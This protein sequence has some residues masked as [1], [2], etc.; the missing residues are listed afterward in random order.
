MQTTGSQGWHWAGAGTG[1]GLR[2]DAVCTLPSRY[3]H[4]VDEVKEELLGILLPVGGE[5]GVALANEGLE[6]PRGDAILH[7]L[8]G[9]G[10]DSA[11]AHQ[12]APGPF[13]PPIPG[14]GWGTGPQT[15]LLLWGLLPV[16]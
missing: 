9:Q 1:R 4:H 5:L 14:P 8:G 7:L 3:L 16:T 13:L 6:H 11:V 12:V 10:G 15:H 2:V